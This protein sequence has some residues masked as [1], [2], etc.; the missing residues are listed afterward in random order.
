MRKIRLTAVVVGLALA[1]IP[2]SAPSSTAGTAM[3]SHCLTMKNRWFPDG[4]FTAYADTFCYNPIGWGP[5]DDPNWSD[6]SGDFRTTDGSSAMSVLNTGWGAEADVVAV[7]DYANYDF[8]GGYRCL[9]TGDWESDLSNFRFVDPNGN[10]KGPMA[11][12]ISSHQWVYSSGCAA[13]SW[14]GLP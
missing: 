13:A 1:A 2:M 9:G 3:E 14:I 6:N 11:R 4:N 7:Y 10:P 5:G 8:A 12:A